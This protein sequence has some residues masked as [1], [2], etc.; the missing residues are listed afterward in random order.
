[1]SLL[2]FGSFNFLASWGYIDWIPFLQ[3]ELLYGFGPALFIYTKSLTDQSYRFTRIEWMHFVLPLLEFIYYRT[4]Y[5][6]NG[7]ISLSEGAVTQ[8]NYIYQI[9]QWGGLVSLIIYLLLTVRLLLKYK[10]WLKDRFSNLQNR[11]LDWL[12][13]PVILYLVFC[14]IWIPTR[15][16]DILFFSET[17][18]NYYFN[19]GFLSLAM[20]TFWIGFKGYITTH[21][22]SAGFVDNVK[23]SPKADVI[24][25]DLPIIAKDLEEQMLSNAH[26]LDKD[27]SLNTFAK[28]TGYSQKEISKALNSCLKLSF[29]EF[30]NNYR[31]D[32]FKKNLEK[33]QF[34]HLSLLGLAL[35]SG[36]GSKSSFNL[37]FKSNTGI[38][39]KKFKEQLLK[40]K[41]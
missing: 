8:E 15:S 29:H 25:P 10:K 39:P 22:S 36:F 2:N 17:L 28:L 12:E 16:I 18:R 14:I 35:E 7:A 4:S 21:I 11:E 34:E 37:V 20:I 19:L 1:M 9:V 13:K 27:L 32:A 33:K 41:S 5:F 24:D 26:Y 31:V 38:T 30:V 23:V 6:R 3:L 40:K